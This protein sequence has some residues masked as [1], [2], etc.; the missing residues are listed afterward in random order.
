MRLPQFAI[1][2]VFILLSNSS[3]A[4]SVVGINWN[5]GTSFESKGE[6]LKGFKTIVVNL[7]ERNFS[8]FIISINKKIFA[9]DCNQKNGCE[10]L[11][12][13]DVDSGRIFFHFNDKFLAV[14]GDRPFRQTNELLNG[15]DTLKVWT[16]KDTIL[17]P[18]PFVSKGKEGS[19]SETERKEQ[20]IFTSVFCTDT[21]KDQSIVNGLLG[22]RFLCPSDTQKETCDCGIPIKNAYE[23]MY[24]PPCFDK[25][26]NAISVKNHLL[27]D[28]SMTDPMQKVFL[29]KIRKMNSKKNEDCPDLTEK[30][31]QFARI[32]RKMAPSVGDIMAISVI[33]H[34]DSTIHIDSNY[35]NFFLDSA[36]A[37]GKAFTAATTS[38]PAESTAKSQG[39]TTKKDSLSILYLSGTVTLRDDL[40]YFN[41]YYKDLNFIQEKYYAPLTCLQ[42]NI[43]KFFPF[44]IIPKSGNELALSIESLLI[45]NNLPK[46]YYRFACQLLKQIASEYDIALNRKSDYRIYTRVFQVPNADEF[47]VSM[48]TGKSKDPFYDHKFQ[49][50]G[51]IKIDF[52][53]G[54][55]LTG[56]N[57]R[58]YVLTSLR[59]RFKDSLNGAPRDTV[60]NLISPNANKL[61]YSFGFL[62][63]VYRRS[64]YYI[65]TGLVTGV[66]F[67]NSDFMMLLGGSA[68]FRFGNIRLS[69]VGG[70]A[71]G[72]Q[73]NLDAN[74]SQY[75]YDPNIYPTSKEY[76]QD[77]LPTRLPRFFTE[78]NITTYEKLKSSW[79]AGIAFNFAS[80]KL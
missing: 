64:G 43:T 13:S 19:K 24:L 10:P 20:N 30:Y 54:I 50:K 28:M 3:P 44:P 39:N 55:V 25:H 56:L 53:T 74:H 27:F 60:G 77:S 73:K 42:V 18:I 47:S 12:A 70:W 31:F 71:F 9:F 23:N 78:T 37:A 75:L 63:H 26:G 8:S 46:I 17:I 69:L 14:I 11:I 34:K 5:T 72:K 32:K 51:G 15:K 21:T 22:L 45:S 1:I 36:V 16:G 76:I 49:V 59:F 65:N 38:P 48:R 40:T 6:I 67:N 41:N 2:A 61:N 57:S 7:P 68:M 66:T 79:F 80:I 4:Q 29:F 35:V 52:S 33:A 62:V 58:D